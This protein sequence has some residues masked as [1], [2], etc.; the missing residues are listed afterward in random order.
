MPEQVRGQ[1]RVLDVDIIRAVETL[2]PIA[3]AMELG[4]RPV[5]VNDGATPL[6]LAD[7]RAFHVE[8]TGAALVASEASAVEQGKT[9]R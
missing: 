1:I 7:A 8:L 3:P 2:P 4:P 5:A 6:S 9:R